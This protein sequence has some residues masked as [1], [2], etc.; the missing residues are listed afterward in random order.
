MINQETIDKIFDAA[1][2]VDVIGDF[3]KLKKRGVNHVGLC[4]FHDEKTPSFTVS[5]AKGIYKCF[6]CGQSGGVVNFVMEHENKNFP[7]ALRYLAS[8]Y[9]IEI[10]E[11]KPS[12]Q[13]EENHKLKEQL[14]FINEKANGFFKSFENIWNPENTLTLEYLKGRFTHDQILQFQIGYAHDTWDS[15]LNYFKSL[16]L[17]EEYVLKSNLIKES[18]KTKKLYDFFRNRIIFPIFDI[19]SRVIAFGGRSI[20]NKSKSYESKYLNS[21]DSILYDKSRVLYGL[22]FAYKSIQKQDN[23]YTVEGYTDVIKLH[24]LNITNTVAPCGTAFTKEHA[25][26]IRRYTKNITLIYDAD[27]SGK[28]AADKNSK[29]AI[30]NGLNVYIAN[31]PDKEDPD[32]FFKSTEQFNS[33]IAENRKDYILFCSENLFSSSGND[34]ILRHD[35]INS[36]CCLLYYFDKSTQDIYIEQIAKIFKIKAKL[37]F[38]KLSDLR[39][40]N[41]KSADSDS[42]PDIINARDFEKWGFYSYKN[43]YYFRTKN[44]NERLSN[45][46]MKPVFHIDSINDSKRIYELINVYGHRVVVD[47]DMQEMTSLQSFCKHIEGKGNYLFWGS[48][49]HFSKLKLRLYEQTRT[50]NEVKILGWQKEGFWAWSNGMITPDGF[51]EIDE[52]GIIKFNDLNYFI[53]AFSKIY[54]HDKSIFLDERKFKY[55]NRDVSLREWS[56]LYIKVFGNNA[57]ISI[58]FWIATI[59]R[60]YFLYIFKNFPLLNLFGPKGTGKSQ[61]AMSLS[62]LFGEQ[63]TPFNIHNGTKP[64][65]AEHIQ[66]FCNAFAWVDEYKNNLDYDKIETLKSIYDAIGRSRLN[67]NKG[68]KKETTQVNSAVILSGQE[69]PTGDVALF[70]RTIFLQFHQTEFNK[71]EKSNYDKLKQLERAGLSHLTTEIIKKRKY[72][73]ENFYSVYEN[74]LSDFSEATKDKVIED[75]ILRSMCSIVAAFKTL[76]DEFDF[77]FNY[78]ELKPIA[79]KAIKDQNSQIQKSN[80]IGMFWDMLEAMFDENIIKEGWHFRLK[81]MDSI[82]NT[83]GNTRM[84]INPA[85]VLLFKFTTIA[86]LYSENLRKSGNKPLPA[87]TLRYYLENNKHFFGIAKGIKFTL[88]EYSK[89]EGRIIEKKTSTTAYCFDYKKLNINLR[90]QSIMEFENIDNINNKKSE[91]ILPDKFI[92]PSVTMFVKD[93]LPF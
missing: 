32:S 19:N 66:Q 30:E 17:K 34:P 88:K 78:D 49:A 14:Y 61:M 8:K 23:C 36:V 79:I 48:L 74:V 18:E 91:N 72:F 27:R 47:L 41:S 56:E 10:K 33:Y 26:L 51:K 76:Q 50:C 11:E 1:V 2:I 54:I 70:S 35:A 84:L 75:R 38:D 42:L 5:N 73:C 55:K 81:Y 12:K 44:G 16:Y 90:R 53:P 3:V 89:D 64:G 4:P 29:I 25:R 80:E 28:N 24:S 58:A 92:E 20:P 67:I 15:L 9:N 22:N 6:G 31:L 85:D 63:Q 45:F 71:T 93:N 7:D 77:P 87:D 21:P 62:C 46:I 86:K 57:K 83:K 68:L 13:D 59:F 60:D 65:L 69:M 39:R 52:Y 43:E 37:F 82:T 40:E